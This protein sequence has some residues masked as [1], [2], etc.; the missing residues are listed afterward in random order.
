MSIA[1]A[2]IQKNI[3]NRSLIDRFF[4]PVG[5]DGVPKP[6]IAFILFFAAQGF[7]VSGVYRWFQEK[8][9]FVSG[10]DYF[11]PE[12]QAI[13]MNLMWSQLAGI[14]LLGLFA[15]VWVLRTRDQNLENLSPQRELGRYYLILSTLFIATILKLS[16]LS[17][18]LE[19]DAAWHQVTIRDTDFTPTHIGLFYFI[20][21][22]DAV[23]MI[24]G[25]LWAHTRLPDFNKR[26]SI[27][28]LMI[29]SAPLLIM[30]SLGFNEWGHTFFYAE[31]LFAAPVHYGFVVLGWGF[32]AISGFLVQI[33]SGLH[34]LTRTT[35][36]LAK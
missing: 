17:F 20:M 33:I 5:D 22:L 35:Q 10:L 31:E 34:R 19:S 3:K 36:D 2:H 14:A 4:Y 21:P 32:L 1:A 23:F 9:A 28:L 26:V 25:S 13:W 29:A 27:P 6:P 16:A 18:F 7:L 8:N 11:E 12:F 24:F 15:V 30:P